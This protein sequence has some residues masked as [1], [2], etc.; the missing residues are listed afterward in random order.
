MR[1][2]MAAALLTSG[3]IGVCAGSAMADGQG[4]NDYV[5]DDTW[6]CRPGRDDACSADLTT[7]VVRADGSTAQE[8][9]VADAEAPIDC[10]YVYPTVS[11]DTSPNSDMVAGPE[12]MSVIQQQFARFGA[13]CRVYAPLY[14]QITLTALRARMS[15]KP[16]A[17]DRE[18][19]Y[20]D[21]RDAWHHYLANDNQGRGVVLV[22]HSQGAGVL[23]EL[24]SNEVDGQPIQAR[25]VS[26]MLLG[27]R[28]QVPPGMDVGGSF[29]HMPLCR[30]NRQT[31]CVVTYASFR[32][33]VP[34]PADSLF[35]QGAEG[36]VAACTNPAN[37]TGGPGALHAYLATVSRGSAAP[38]PDWIDDGTQIATPFVSVPGLL[39]A[40]CVSNDRGSYL[41]VTVAADPDDPRTDDIGGDIVAGGEVQASW[42][43]HLIDVNLAMGNLLDLVADQ[44][45]A[46]LQGSE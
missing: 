4:A 20:A 26:A 39:R 42:G 22:G 8:P 31:G 13:E 12:E 29:A 23:T 2:S 5:D 30:D 17:A 25:I 44:K 24:I 40:Q 18:L 7:T 28:V 19:A 45:A 33:T 41:E 34:P 9:F 15:G 43:L 36:T 32:D 16:M 35:G 27:T 3:L 46:Y 21:V 14:R 37:L 6:L 10:F 1:L 11:T 38:T